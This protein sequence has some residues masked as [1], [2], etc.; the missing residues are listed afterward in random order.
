MKFCFKLGK[1]PPETHKMLVTVYADEAVTK[2]T[3]FKWFQRFQ[4]GKESLE[5]DERSGRPS[6][7]RT[8]ENITQVSIVVHHEN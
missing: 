6:T 7:A 1:T 2:K 8:D 3:V 5:D 4:E